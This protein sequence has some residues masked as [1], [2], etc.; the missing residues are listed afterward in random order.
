MNHY[1]LKFFCLL[2]FGLAALNTAAD[3]SSLKNELKAYQIVFETYRDNNWELCRID[4]DGSNLVN[5][6]QTKNCHEM[7]PKVSPDGTKIC[8]VSDEDSGGE[9]I[10][11]VYY[12][13]A[14]GSERKKSPKERANL[15]GVPTAKKSP[16]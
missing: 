7:Y 5:L 8:F 4:A 6:T 13:N 11:S 9:T 10:R 3:M 1:A 14:N 16:I 2:I 15:A 12:M